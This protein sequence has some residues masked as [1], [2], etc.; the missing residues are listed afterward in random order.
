MKRLTL[1]LSAI[2]LITPLA[3][4]QTAAKEIKAKGVAHV[5]IL[6]AIAGAPAADVYFDGK[7]VAENIAFKAISEYLDVESGKTA[8]KM[9][10]AGK[11]ATILDGAA[12]FTRDA[13]YTIVP[14]GTMDKAKIS[15]QNDNTGKS[16]DAKARIRAF[17]LA[18]GAPILDIVF[19]KGIADGADAIKNLEYGEDATK[20]I[21]PGAA[22][23]Q[24]RA[25]T[26]VIAEVPVT[27]EAGKKYA[28]FVVGKPAAAGAQAFDVLVKPS[29]P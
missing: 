10:A 2:L 24:V 1:S 15:S 12:T 8:I 13:Y 21:E 7:K 4:A 27:L 11:E 23:L 22:T 9:T 5:R 26:R 28:I 16:D 19:T 25:G 18:P 3:W 6:H 17:H 14:F 29:K 20:L